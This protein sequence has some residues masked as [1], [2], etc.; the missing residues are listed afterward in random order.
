MQE[1]K[2][3]ILIRVYILYV[4]IILFS[5]IIIGQI[6][7]IQFSQG[8]YWKERAKEFSVRTQVIKATRGNIYADDGK[9][10]LATSVPIFE[11]RLN[12]STIVISDDDFSQTVGPLADSLSGLFKDRSSGEYKTLMRKGRRD[13][14][15]GGYLLI[16]KDVL[17]EQLKRIKKFPK[18]K[19]GRNVI[20]LDIKQYDKRVMP[21]DLLAKRTIG[22][23]AIVPIKDS[24]TGKYRNDTI[25]VGLEG[26]FSK[27]VKRLTGVNG[28]GLVRLVAGGERLPLYNDSSIVEPKNGKDIVTTIN[29]DIQEVAQNSLMENLIKNKA[30]HGCAVL[31]EVAT[32][33]I[34]AIV[35][36]KRDSVKGKTIFSEAFNYAIGEATDPGSTFK[37]VSLAV[38]LEDKVVDTNSLFN[39]DF[40]KK[41][42]GAKIVSDVH[43]LAGINTVKSIFEHSSNIGTTA[44]IWNNYQN[45]PKKFIDGLYRLNIQKPLGLTIFGEK[46]PDIKDTKSKWWHTEYSLPSMAFG[47]EVEI[48]PLQILTFYNAIANNGKMVRPMFVKEIREMGKLEQTFYPTVIKQSVCSKETIGKLRKMMEGVVE[49]GTGKGCFKSSLYKVAGKTGTAQINYVNKNKQKMIY[50]ASFAGY[51]PADKPKYSCIVVITNPS[52]GAFYG[53]AV[54]APVFK[55]IADKVYSALLNNYQEQ[56][57]S[58][59][60]DFAPVTKVVNNYDIKKINSDFK[61]PL[62]GSDIKNDWV[63][64]KVDSTLNLSV[65][66]ISKAGDIPNV[67]GM[68]LKDAVFTLEN[69]GYKVTFNGKGIVKSAKMIRVKE[70]KLELS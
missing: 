46:A 11:L 60:K 29:V 27:K 38:A 9:Q 6:I 49:R 30:E 32:G 19:T 42:F 56:P 21:Y 53:G 17:Y 61:Y 23:N 37:L 58:A 5:F 62:T 55:D 50:R 31:M 44:V 69:S 52:A 70:V 63:I 7:R 25:Y 35:N 26:Y 4:C 66:P 65:N 10:L 51:F 36:L 39:T 34:K 13:K 43:V 64:A 22:F 54:A 28:K 67:I 15:R 33:Q 20:G 59:K 41:Q 57:K 1:I 40:S 3:T 12:A 48:T 68:G 18:F 47:Y 45:N 8:K 2:N 14:R 24:I 16:K